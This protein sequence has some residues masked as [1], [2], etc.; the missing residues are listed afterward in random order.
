[1]SRQPKQ[2][3]ARPALVLQPRLDLAL[4]HPVARHGPKGRVAASRLR[5]HRRSALAVRRRTSPSDGRSGGSSWLRRAAASARRSAASRPLPRAARRPSRSCACVRNRPL[6]LAMWN[7]RLTERDA[8]RIAGLALWSRRSAP[9]RGGRSSWSARRRPG[10]GRPGRSCVRVDERD[11]LGREREPPAF[12]CELL[13]P[14][15]EERERASPARALPSVS[16]QN[17]SCGVDAGKYASRFSKSSRLTSRRSLV[18]SSKK[19]LVLSS[20]AIPVG[21]MKPER[22]P[23]DGRFRNVSA[24][25]I[26]VDVTNRGQREAAGARERTGSPPR[27]RAWR[28]PELAARAPG[29]VCG[30]ALISRSRAAL[31]GASAISRSRAGE[32]LLLLQL[33][34]LPRR[35]AERHV[36][37]AA[38]EDLGELERPV[39]EAVLLRQ[40]ERGLHHALA[41]G[42]VAQGPEH[43]VGGRDALGRAGRR[44]LQL[45]EERRGPEVARLAQAPEVGVQLAELVVAPP[46]LVHGGG[47]VVLEAPRA[48]ARRGR[49]RPRRRRGPR[50]RTGPASP[51]PRAPAC[52]ASSARARPPCRRR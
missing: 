5:W 44:L 45:G 20:V 28:R 22:P 26:G 12:V 10:C 25:G 27:R 39:E 13:G 38:G 34:P 9:A 46:L 11:V 15:S 37:A 52:C 31:F 7:M 4:E 40:L 35:V 6:S 19:A 42:L 16:R 8:P 50:C 51:A 29:C 43:V 47:A 1:M 23:S 3:A 49:C 41:A 36:E 18:T 21:T 17:L 32:E 2:P 24:K 30:S 14:G 33:D 48:R